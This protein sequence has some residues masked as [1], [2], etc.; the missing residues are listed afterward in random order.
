MFVLIFT[1]ILFSYFSSFVYKTKREFVNIPSLVLCHL[2]AI[3]VRRFACQEGFRHIYTLMDPNQNRD[4]PSD[5]NIYSMYCLWKGN[6]A[7]EV[8]QGSYLVFRAVTGKEK[9][10]F[11]SCHFV[12]HKKWSSNRLRGAWFNPP[13]S[14]SLAPYHQSQYSSIRREGS[15]LE[16]L[17][18][19]IYEYIPPYCR[20]SSYN[21]GTSLSHRDGF[22]PQS[23]KA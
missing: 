2:E 3:K 22:S 10:L 4:W 1:L 18:S 20:L 11:T 8:G 23:I 17:C 19:H 16:C 14:V 13:T 5:P 7:S 12:T 6:I 9:I 21:T 15:R